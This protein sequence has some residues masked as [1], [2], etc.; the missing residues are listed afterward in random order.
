MTRARDEFMQALLTF[1]PHNSAHWVAIR[2]SISTALPLLVLVAIGHPEWGA[3]A[4]FGAFASLYGR[5]RVHLT[6]LMMQL[7]AAAVMVAAVGLGS[8]V[9]TLPAPVWPMI[10]LGAL[11]AG[12][13][14]IV[15]DA[16]D[17]H[18]PGPLFALFAFSG[19][20]SLPDI[21]LADAGLA[22]GVAA[23]SAA[24][25]VLVGS[26]GTAWRRMRGLPPLE[27]LPVERDYRLSAGRR[28]QLRRVARYA[29]SVLLAGSIATALGIGHPYWAMV[30]AVVPVSTGTFVAG[31]ARGTQRIVGTTVGVLL[32]A[33]ILVTRP[34]DL[35]LVLMI[36]LVAFG[37]ELL[38]G[39]NYGIAMMFVTPLALLAVHLSSPVPVEQLVVDRLVESIVGALVGIAVGFATRRW[40]ARLV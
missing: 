21:S 10:A 20:A 34:S 13:V 38:V 12:L 9:A 32:A 5:N 39:R 28:V 40:G 22:T 36:A 11:F 29:L 8:L 19:S 31:L 37:T 33:A 27:S 7:T 30:S 3:W 35:V 14:S 17:W 24:F 25:A 6:R 18:P 2:A 16:E 26:V 15:S 1:G 4:A 23:A